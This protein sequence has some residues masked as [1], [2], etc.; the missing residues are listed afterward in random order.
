MVQAAGSDSRLLWLWRNHPGIRKN[1]FDQ[2]PISWEEHRKW[3]DS[4]IKDNKTKIYIA[5]IEKEKIGVIRFEV[6]TYIVKVSVN[7]NPSFFGKRLGREIIRLGTEIFFNE[8]R[9]IKP[10]IAK[11][12]KDN[13]ASQKAFAKAGYTYQKESEGEV[14]YKKER[15]NV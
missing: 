1:F 10:V 9:T 7:L 5:S 12:K 8:T 2:K 15:P 4:R 11:I 14:V 3:F 13:I 6:D